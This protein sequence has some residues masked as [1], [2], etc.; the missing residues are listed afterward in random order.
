[1][2]GDSCGVNLHSA[3]YFCYFQITPRFD[4]VC[5]V[6]VRWENKT[7]NMNYSFPITMY[8]SISTKIYIFMVE[9]RF[10]M[11]AEKNTKV[12]EVTLPASCDINP[13]WFIHFSRI[14]FVYVHVRFLS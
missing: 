6:V 12:F 2:V 4:S 8:E 9:K 3:A 10:T 5:I 11:F 1:M 13:V 14:A 7:V